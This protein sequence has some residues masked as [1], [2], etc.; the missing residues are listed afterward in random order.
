METGG[1]N[2]ALGSDF[3]E[4]LL[5]GKRYAQKE[6]YDRFSGKMYALCLRYAGN[7]PLAEDML[8]E[9]FIKVFNNLSQFKG[10]GSFEGWMRRIFVNT[11]IEMLRRRS[12]KQRPI[13][14][15]D[16]DIP[17][18]SLTSGY[19]KV[20][21]ADLLAVIQQLPEGYRTI[22][23]L[24]VLEGYSHKEIAQLLHISE[25]TSKSQL[26]RA[27]QLLQKYFVLKG[28]TV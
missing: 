27:K 19:D 15:G 25:G 5:S 1:F 14:N 2:M 9:G 12:L 20:S 18:S 10:E 7:Q 4:A 24:Y 8:Q 17:Q 23:N 16:L 6:L 26:A 11:A 21:L 13:E 28:I 3:W 22:F